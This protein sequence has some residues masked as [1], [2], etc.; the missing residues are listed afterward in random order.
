MTYVAD[1]MRPTVGRELTELPD[2]Q[3]VERLALIMAASVGVTWAKLDHDAAFQLRVQANAALLQ[4]GVEA[5]D[6]AAIHFRER[7][8]QAAESLRQ[9]ANLASHNKERESLIQRLHRD[10]TSME[11]LVMILDG[12]EPPVLGA[13]EAHASIS[14][15]A[16]VEEEAI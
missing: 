11:S 3:A 15:G 6:G 7:I 8:R 9:A 13:S 1:Q 4:F 14:Q 5:L 16:Q 2:G 12:S 10:A